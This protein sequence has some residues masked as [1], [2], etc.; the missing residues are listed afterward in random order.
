MDSFRL[1][2][3][4]TTYFDRLYEESQGRKAF[5]P[6]ASGSSSLHRVAN[7]YHEEPKPREAEEGAPRSRLRLPHLQTE[8]DV[9]GKNPFTARE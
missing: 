6:G 3:A 7:P 8:E 4:V 1:G 2:Q 9:K 5:D